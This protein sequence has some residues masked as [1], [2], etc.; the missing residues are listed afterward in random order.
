[1]FFKQQTIR[2]ISFQMKLGDAYSVKTYQSITSLATSPAISHSSLY[3]NGGY[4]MNNDIAAN[5]G[6][7]S[8]K[9]TV[10]TNNTINNNT[11]NMMTG[12]NKS[13]IITNPTTT[14][15]AKAIDRIHSAN[16]NSSTIDHS[17]KATTNHFGQILPSFLMAKGRR[18]T[19]SENSHMWKSRDK[20]PDSENIEEN[21]NRAILSKRPNSFQERRSENEK[22]SQKSFRNSFPYSKSHENYENPVLNFPF[23]NNASKVHYD[24]NY[25]SDEDALS[26]ENTR[27]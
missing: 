20:N 18:R 14:I 10:T 7:I 21:C 23:H 1:M 25:V 16:S 4:L 24:D 15:A 19:F 5:I 27:L 2:C 6:T 11:A 13:S 3:S 12:N 9:A 26:V 8:N 17:N 22:F